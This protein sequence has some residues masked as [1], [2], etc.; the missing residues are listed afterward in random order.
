MSGAVEQSEL[1]DHVELAGD[2]D[3]RPD[4]RRDLAHLQYRNTETDETAAYR[5]DSWE[6]KCCGHRMKMNLLEEVDRV[7]EQRPDLSR[8][9]TLTVDPARVVDREAAHEEI[10][11]AWN[12][13]K[14]YLRASHGDF[15]YIWVRE[16]HESGYPHLHVL[17]SRFLPQ[18]DVASA[19]SR[20]G[21]GD[22]VDIRQVNARKAGHYVAKY[23]AKD[24]M[25]HLPSGVH[26]YGSSAD[27][28][29]D[30]RGSSSEES[31]AWIL[32]AEDDVTGLVLEACPSDFIRR[33]PDPP[34]SGD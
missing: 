30:V 9:L 16:E 13:L 26:R 22:V 14:S 18:S 19:W 12:R 17:V 4:C 6:C 34:P 33:R 32:E 31:T 23:V 3:R 27:L 21:M 11:G 8:L 25:A 29:L 10:G 15:S 28:D 2:R 24:A 5:C 7:V 20:T 1:A